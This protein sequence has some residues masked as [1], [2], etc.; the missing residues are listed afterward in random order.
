MR[1]GRCGVG[2]VSVALVALTVELLVLAWLVGSALW[3][4]AGAVIA[5][6]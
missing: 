1:V 2:K 4:M 6:W 5:E 3:E